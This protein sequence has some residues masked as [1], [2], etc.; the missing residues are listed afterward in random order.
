MSV[1]NFSVF[2]FLN[3]H[4]LPYSTSASLFCPLEENKMPFTLDVLRILPIP[5]QCFGLSET[6]NSTRIL[7]TLTTVPKTS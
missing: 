1:F 7:T 2:I 6:G 4:Y 3:Y 5:P